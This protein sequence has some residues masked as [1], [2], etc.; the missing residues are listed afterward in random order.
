MTCRHFGI[1]RQLYYTW[2]RPYRAEGLQQACGIDR[3]ALDAVACLVPPCL[4]RG[5]LTC[6]S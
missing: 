6:T 4:V 3:S 1:S 5:R 2:L